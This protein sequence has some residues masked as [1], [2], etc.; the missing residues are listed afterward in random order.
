MNEC[1]NANMI[2]TKQQRQKWEASFFRD[3]VRVNEKKSVLKV[4][5]NALKKQK[6]AA[7]IVLFIASK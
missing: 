3:K 1:R 4:F 2:K 5:K 6:N 7:E